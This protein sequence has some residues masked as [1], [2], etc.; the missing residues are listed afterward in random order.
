VSD[1]RT[2][3][4]LIATAGL[5]LG[6]TLGA[7][8]L[9]ETASRTDGN[10]EAP[11]ETFVLLD[12]TDPLRPEQVRSLSDLFASLEESLQ[13]GEGVS[14]WVLAHF[15]EGELRHIFRRRYP[16]REANPLIANPRFA[17]LRCD[18]LFSIP[19]T[20]SIANAL[21]FSGASST[22]LLEC[23]RDLSE[24]DIHRVVA[25]RFILVSDLAENSAVVSLY[26]AGPKPT[27]FRSTRCFREY[28]ADLRG[29][30]VQVVEIARAQTGVSGRLNRRA[31][32]KAYFE[33][34][35][36]PSVEFRRL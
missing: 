3:I 12:L 35:G 20:Q 18:S 7:G 23:I 2:G 22:P 26:S 33:A 24:T 30:A 10:G 5:L 15:P 16:G 29:T 25:R 9:L 6:L 21:P 32:W 28:R 8:A 36:A 19:L 11:C 13:S 14:V 17:A 27:A 31:F 4:L 34:C 1:D